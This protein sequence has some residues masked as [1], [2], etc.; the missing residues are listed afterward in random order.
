MTD[1]VSNSFALTHLPP[2]VVRLG[3]LA[4]RPRVVAT[5][6]IVA[7]TA[8][9]WSVL[10]GALAQTGGPWWAAL[11]GQL[12][13]SALLIVALWLAM[14]LAMMLPTAAPMLLT[15]AEIAETA[16]RKGER[17]VSPLLLAAGY[18]AV[19]IGAALV[20]A[21]AQISFASLVPDT[22]TRPLTAAAFVGAG[23]YQFTALK[24]ACLSRC[25]QPFSF[26]FLNWTTTSRGVFRLGAR[27]GLDCLGCCW[28][29][30]ALMFVSGA[31]N[32]VW[33]A[34]LAIYMT[35]EKLGSG[36]WLT[37]IGGVVLI[38]IGLGFVAINI[39]TG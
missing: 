28:A 4:A 8:L 9:G 30:M 19:W 15:Y 26:F 16:A 29:M 12:D 10:G 7:L 13:V 36:R 3:W 18:C 11:C 32:V 14:V 22:W 21:A 17:I 6:C 5:G 1:H 2:A 34:A 39:V 24:H 23:L 35:A 31:M 33:M 20:A 38:A 25:R 37:R 27:Q